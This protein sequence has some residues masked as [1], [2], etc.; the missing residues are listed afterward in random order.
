MTVQGESAPLPPR[1]RPEVGRDP[2]KA[3]NFI[4]AQISSPKASTL[5]DIPDH[6]EK[7]PAHDPH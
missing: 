6:G 3:L 7:E 2:R 1:K 5:T 4:L